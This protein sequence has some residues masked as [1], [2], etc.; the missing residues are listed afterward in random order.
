[1]KIVSSKNISA[2]VKLIDIPLGEC[3]EYACGRYMRVN[4]DRPYR[5]CGLASLTNG[6][7]IRRAADTLVTSIKAEVHL[8]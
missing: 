8:L 7:V 6:I 1:M 2:M 3:C 5:V 4:S